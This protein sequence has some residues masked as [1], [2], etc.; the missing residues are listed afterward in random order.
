M[1]EE[2]S[3]NNPQDAVDDDDRSSVQ[4]EDNIQHNDDSIETTDDNPLEPEPNSV[5]QIQEAAL[6]KQAKEEFSKAVNEN[7]SVLSEIN[8][9]MSTWYLVNKGSNLKYDKRIINWY[10]ASL[11]KKQEK[12][13]LSPSPNTPNTPNTRSTSST[14]GTPKTVKRRHKLLKDD[15]APMP[16]DFLSAEVQTS[17]EDLVTSIDHPFV[18]EYV[19]DE[20]EDCL[21]SDTKTDD[22]YTVIQYLYETPFA[23]SNSAFYI[24]EAIRVNML[25]AIRSRRPLKSESQI[26]TNLKKD[27]KLLCWDGT[28]LLM[29]SVGSDMET[30][31]RIVKDDNIKRWSDL[32]PFKVALIILKATRTEKIYP[33][34]NNMIYM[35]IHR[36]RVNDRIF[37]GWYIGLVGLTENSNS[38][39]RKRWVSHC[40][41][42]A[43]AIDPEKKD[44]AVVDTVLA[45]CGA[46]DSI[47]VPVTR[48][49]SNT[50]MK[51]VEKYLV[52]VCATY[53]TLYG[54]NMD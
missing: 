44:P 14:S 5:Q 2:E 11:Y 26:K 34:T 28:N 40:D 38:T 37:V 24:K 48:F 25:A 3:P 6:L 10:L 35:S 17:I 16:L 12:L 9:G 4:V 41:D 19:A 31:S 13:V 8:C 39:Y 43:R 1:S 7:K 50:S 23:K 52:S 36:I 54:L 18:V 32:V 15:I 33:T 47:V 21:P 30:G 53:Y 29:N 42:A 45:F 51:A 27:L 49:A 22:V 20:D 46:D